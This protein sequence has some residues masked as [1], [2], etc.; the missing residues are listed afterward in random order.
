M[1]MNKIRPCLLYT[2][3]QVSDANFFCVDTLEIVNKTVDAFRW[4]QLFIHQGTAF[5]WNG[6]AI[7]L[8]LIHIFS[9]SCLASAS[10]K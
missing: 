10:T 4:K 2:S 7:A 8:S 9:V 6:Q 3:R 1:D 5:R